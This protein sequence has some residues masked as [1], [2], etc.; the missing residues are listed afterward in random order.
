MGSMK[1][2]KLIVMGWQGRRKDG[3]SGEV[4]HVVIW[5]AK[6]ALP[7]GPISLGQGPLLLDGL[8]GAEMPS[9]LK[10]RIFFKLRPLL[11]L[12]RNSLVTPASLKIDL[13]SHKPQDYITN[14]SDGFT[15]HEFRIYNF[16]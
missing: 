13:K 3:K 12:R 6:S 4:G 15:N 5:W 16:F 9:F 7:P 1:W 11:R 2:A 14:S 10:I 8:L